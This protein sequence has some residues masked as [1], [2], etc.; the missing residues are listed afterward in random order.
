MAS[1]D[2]FDFSPPREDLAYVFI[3]LQS[4]TFFVHIYFYK[5]FSRKIVRIRKPNAGSNGEETDTYC[6][7]TF[8][9]ARIAKWL[10]P[11]LML[12]CISH[13]VIFSLGIYAVDHGITKDWR[14]NLRW[15]YYL[16]IMLEPTGLLVTLLWLFLYL[17]CL[18]MWF[19]V[20]CQKGHDAS[21]ILFDLQ[22]PTPPA[23]RDRLDDFI[24]R[25]KYRLDG[26]IR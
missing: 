8:W 15:A 13:I 17:E 7:Y 10:Q 21:E 19:L 25:S 1:S 6:V 16:N 4:V 18:A 11:A 3:G 12:E 23:M 24:F 22:N 5:V 2:I 26:S 9:A 14:D 20:H